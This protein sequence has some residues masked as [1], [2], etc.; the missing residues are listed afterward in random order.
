MIRMNPLVFNLL[1]EKSEL[2]PKDVYL[3]RHQDARARRNVQN[4]KKPTPYE[5][6]RNAREKFEIYQSLQAKKCF[7]KRKYLASFVVTPQKETL[8]VGVYQRLGRVQIPDSVQQCPVTG[9]EVSDA[10]HVYY[11]LV[12]SEKLK[13]LS[14]KVTIEWGRGYLRWVQLAD[15]QEKPILEIRAAIDEPVFPGM[16]NFLSEIDSTPSLP[17][18]WQQVLASHKGIYLLRC[19]DTGR[20]YV[21]KADG[22]RGFFGR[23]CDYAVNGHGGNLNMKDHKT[24]GYWAT[25]L[26]AVST[27]DPEEL[28][29]REKLWKAKLGSREKW[30]LNL[31]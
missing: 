24:S 16:R 19:K 20:L 2:D 8:F 3:V 18:G 7:D 14:E 12:L 23:F 5:L 10:N 25:I 4:G 21:G 13:E 11:E 9:I 1:L 17:K 29:K 27:A 28:D 6:W 30:G 31:N 22:E 15:N 26:E